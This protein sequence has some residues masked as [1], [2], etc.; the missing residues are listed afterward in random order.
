M[1]AGPIGLRARLDC[2]L[3]PRY[4]LTGKVLRE[5]RRSW[6]RSFM[7]PTCLDWVTFHIERGTRDGRIRRE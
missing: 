4:P 3:S 1:F 7:V 2:G 6:Q 5:A